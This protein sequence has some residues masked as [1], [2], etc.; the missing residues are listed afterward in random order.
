ML[1][2]FD[3]VFVVG[4]KPPSFSVLELDGI[5]V[6]MICVKCFLVISDRPTPPF[7]VFCVWGCLSSAPLC[8]VLSM[9]VTG[10]FLLLDVTG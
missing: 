1:S 8:L 7:G 6:L 9:C 10:E 2:S 5:M 4:V 3:V